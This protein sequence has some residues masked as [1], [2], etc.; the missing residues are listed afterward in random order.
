[1]KSTILAPDYW[2]S[3]NK[4]AVHIASCEVVINQ[5]C[6][7]CWPLLAT[8]QGPVA[9]ID[10]SRPVS[11]HFR[12]KVKVLLECIHVRRFNCRSLAS[13]NLYSNDSPRTLPSIPLIN[14]LRVEVSR[15]SIETQM[16]DFVI[17]ESFSRYLCE[18]YL[19][20]PAAN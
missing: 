20:L 2:S 8:G 1:M 10:S 14:H 7:V 4:L 11:T 19:T 18:K 17:L 9:S 3:S 15:S 6:K 16:H 12:K 5:N 13:K